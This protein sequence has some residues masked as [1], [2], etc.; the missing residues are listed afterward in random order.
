MIVFDVCI[1]EIGLRVFVFIVFGFK[2]FI[3]R[4]LF[5]VIKFVRFMVL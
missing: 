2:V 4:V 3:I 1:G 5:F